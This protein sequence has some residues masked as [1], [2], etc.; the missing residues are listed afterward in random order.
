[1]ELRESEK[2]LTVK[3]EKKDTEE[4]RDESISRTL[5]EIL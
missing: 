2:L 3:E 1:M 5:P 4:M